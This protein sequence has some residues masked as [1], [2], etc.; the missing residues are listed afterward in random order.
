MFLNENTQKKKKNSDQ[1]FEYNTGGVQILQNIFKIDTL[2]IHS[3]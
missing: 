1:V 3:F 2:K